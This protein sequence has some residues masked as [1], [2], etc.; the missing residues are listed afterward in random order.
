M[1]VKLIIYSKLKE[2]VEGYDN[3]GIVKEIPSPKSIRQF[4][5][6]TINHDLAMDAISMVIVNDKVVPF[7]Q[8]DSNLKDKDIIKVY[9]PMGGG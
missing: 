4:L 1:K 9:P 5:E 7:K 8:M 6:E 2:Y 3:N